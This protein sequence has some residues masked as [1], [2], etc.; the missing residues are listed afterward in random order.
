MAQTKNL[1]DGSLRVTPSKGFARGLRKAFEKAER[2]EQRA[3][4]RI[5]ETPF[6]MPSRAQL[7]EFV[8]A[9][10]EA[11]REVEPHPKIKALYEKVK[12]VLESWGEIEPDRKT[13]E[14]L[15]ALAKHVRVP[16]RR[17]RWQDVERI[18]QVREL[19]EQGLPF[20]QIAKRIFP[21]ESRETAYPKLLRFKSRHKIQ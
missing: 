21:N 3:W 4:R 17:G 14:I 20:Y 2:Q 1:P 11:F 10:R 15:N 12:P 13:L 19:R 18:G 6:E 9:M 5:L 8:K 16:G 7:R